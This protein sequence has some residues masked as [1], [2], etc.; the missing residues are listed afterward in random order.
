MN[1]ANMERL[2]LTLRA[3]LAQQERL[4]KL[5]LDREVV[6]P[7]LWY[8]VAGFARE[9]GRSP[10]S[11]RRMCREGRIDAR[12]RPVGRGTQLEWEIPRHELLRFKNHGLRTRQQK[13]S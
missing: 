13:G 11:V 2:I 4:E 10:Y 9:I 6:P 8:T 12:K 3:I 1:A 7:P 5:I